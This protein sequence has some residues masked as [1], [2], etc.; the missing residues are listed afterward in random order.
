MQWKTAEAQ[1]TPEYYSSPTDEAQ[2]IHAGNTD[3]DPM[4]LGVSLIN[5][6]A[7]RSAQL[8]HAVIR[9]THKDGAEYIDCD[10]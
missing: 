5:F 2:I 9:A 1:Q 3:V 6:A 8:L 7:R 10:M 4:I